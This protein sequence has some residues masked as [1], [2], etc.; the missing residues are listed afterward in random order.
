MLL[1]DGCAKPAIIGFII[2]P[3]YENILICGNKAIA[4]SVIN[5]LDHPN[6]TDYRTGLDGLAISFIIKRYIARYDGRIELARRI[7]HTKH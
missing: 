5:I 2:L 7:S 1:I 6:H 3:D 4:D